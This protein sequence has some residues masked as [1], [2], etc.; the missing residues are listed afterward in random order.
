M[1]VEE[2]L[3]IIAGFDGDHQM[4]H[5]VGRQDQGRRECSSES[6]IPTPQQL[7]TRSQ[8]SAQLLH[9]LPPWHLGERGKASRVIT[10]KLMEK[11]LFAE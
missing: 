4:V 6:N 1:E 8:R 3:T 10:P 5:I 9:L 7:K 11:A 2:A